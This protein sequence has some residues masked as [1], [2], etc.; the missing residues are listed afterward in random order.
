M[1]RVIKA[2]RGSSSVWVRLY[3]REHW[4]SQGNATTVFFRR[5]MPYI[6]NE[7]SDALWTSLFEYPV[8]APQSWLLLK[9]C[10]APEILILTKCTQHIDPSAYLDAHIL[11]NICLFPVKHVCVRRSVY[12]GWQQWVSALQRGIH[13]WGLLCWEEQPRSAAERAFFVCVCMCVSAPFV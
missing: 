4:R 8:K 9:V 7:A 6:W 3:M 5:L 13:L 10:L 1:L 12:V 2:R 11:T